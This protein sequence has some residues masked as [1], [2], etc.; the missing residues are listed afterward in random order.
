VSLSWLV[1]GQ[2][3]GG[4]VIYPIASRLDREM[5]LRLWTEANTWFSSEAG[6]KGQIKAGQLADLA[7]LSADYFSVP[8]DDIADITSVLTLL[9]GKPVHGA[10]EFEDLAP[11]L[12]PAMPDWSPVRRY[13][14]YQAR[15]QQALQ[16][17]HTFAGCGCDRA[18]NVH[19]HVHVGA[20][21]A[22]LPVTDDKAFWGALG[23]SCWAF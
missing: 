9:D 5:A 11:P 12:P 13:G 6:Q 10:A 15:A 23:C 18:C 20:W 8:Q 3:V 1:T 16:R 2:T 14:G 22:D 4:L 19:G 17:N 21:T 7:V